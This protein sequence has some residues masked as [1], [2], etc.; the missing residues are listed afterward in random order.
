MSDARMSETT[1][2][3]FEMHAASRVVAKKKA[4]RPTSPVVEISSLGGLQ[5]KELGEL[6]PSTLQCCAM[7]H[8]SDIAKVHAAPIDDPPRCKDSR[9]E[10]RAAA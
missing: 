8:D 10:M 9:A 7:H 6:A 1:R 5:R 2:E 4:V 3:G